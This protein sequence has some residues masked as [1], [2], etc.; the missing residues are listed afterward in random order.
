ME[1][2]GQVPRT[3]RDRREQEA[4]HSGDRRERT[5]AV[6]SWYPTGRLR[7]QEVSENKETDENKILF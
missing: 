5:I 1:T 3:V 4:S 6:L 7:A 2:C